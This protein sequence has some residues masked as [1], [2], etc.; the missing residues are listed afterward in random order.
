M[1]FFE[2]IEILCRP[3]DQVFH[4]TLTGRSSKS[5]KLC[6]ED[7]ENGKFISDSCGH[8]VFYKGGNTTDEFILS[9][10]ELASYGWKIV[11]S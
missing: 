4:C 7:W 6:H 11:I 2:A 8:L 1:R 3:P 10:Q 5:V 9:A